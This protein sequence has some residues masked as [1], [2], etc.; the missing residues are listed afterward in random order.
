MQFS[1][2]IISILDSLCEKFGIAI[3][4]SQQNVIPYIQQLCSKY[5]KFEIA[6]SVFWCV[7]WFSLFLIAFLIQSKLRKRFKSINDIYDNLDYDIYAQF[8]LAAFCCVFILGIIC[9]IT[10]FCETYDIVTCL[11]FPE[12]II[13]GYISQLTSGATQ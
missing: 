7:I 5:I 3:D 1:E 8:W 4:W 11:T 9:I 2:Q 12:K 10:V 13:I 6:T